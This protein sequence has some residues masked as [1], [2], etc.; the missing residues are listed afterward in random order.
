MPVVYNWRKAR[1]MTQAQLAEEM[2]QSPTTISQKEHGRISW[3][4]RDLEYFVA[5]G[6]SA[7]EILHESIKGK[8]LV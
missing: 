4:Q 5:H 3:Q 7:D 1:G 2:N 6:L 8:E